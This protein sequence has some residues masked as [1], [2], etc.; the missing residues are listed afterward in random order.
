MTET[1]ESESEIDLLP[2][3]RTVSQAEWFQI[4]LDTP[5]STPGGHATMLGKPAP[6][7]ED[8]MREPGC[9]V[10]SKRRASYGWPMHHGRL[11]AYGEDR[12]IVASHAS[13]LPSDPWFIWEGDAAQ[14]HAVWDCD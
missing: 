6:E 12:V 2:G 1:T 3:M 10:K 5:I 9:C 7:P 14:Y 8:A 11:Q 4:Y 13:K